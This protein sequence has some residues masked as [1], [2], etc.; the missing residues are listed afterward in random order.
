MSKEFFTEERTHMN[1]FIHQVCT[2]KLDFM[3]QKYDKVATGFAKFF[4]QDE[5][6][7]V[8]DNMVDR[9]ALLKISQEKASKKEF[10]SAMSIIE[11]LY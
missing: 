2:E 9:K 5:L 3:L 6:F 10:K 11:S 8:V 7:R 4:N 1:S